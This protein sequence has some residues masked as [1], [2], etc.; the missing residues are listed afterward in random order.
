LILGPNHIQLSGDSGRQIEYLM[1]GAPD[2]AKHRYLQAWTLRHDSAFILMFSA[3]MA[4]FNQFKPQIDASLAS[5]L[6]R[7][8][9]AALLLKHTV[10]REITSMYGIPFVDKQ[11]GFR[12]HYPSGWKF[13]TS[14][15]TS[16]A[17]HCEYRGRLSHA[18]DEKEVLLAYDVT[19]EPCN[20][21]LAAYSARL[22]REL[23]KALGRAVTISIAAAPADEAAFAAL[24]VDCDA[25]GQHSL[26]FFPCRVG[27]R[28]GFMTR[29]RTVAL[30]ANASS[31]DA[32]AAASSAASTGAA[33]A[34]S[35]AASAYFELRWTVADDNAY[36]LTFVSTA[37]LDD[38]R[39]EP[40]FA[41]LASSFE[42]VPQ[43]YKSKYATRRYENLQ[44]GVRLDYPTNLAVH[45]KVMGAIVSFVEELPGE[46]FG[47]HVNFV[48]HRLED[49][50][51]SG[52]LEQF[53]ET[54]KQQMP[55]F[56]QDYAIEDEVAI[57]LGGQP[58][59]RIIY[60][61]RLQPFEAKFAQ[62]FTIKDGRAFILSYAVSAPRFED[63]FTRVRET[64][65]DS[66]CFF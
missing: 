37:T 2:G 25:P 51:L 14:R 1:I 19:A 7:P 31:V 50:N 56:V 16:R 64:V 52:D 44:L 22:R 40:L 3:P 38:R 49:M 28:D 62:F 36:V 9:A 55:S 32:A 20:D 21:T 27:E 13:H 59:K 41:R 45:E 47:S 6:I 53:A 46:E 35:A 63:E 58:G 34:S 24:A 10:Q 18:P 11:H 8:E 33:G 12:I 29:F 57:T 23:A 65:I 5:F 17:V 61:G 54:I 60:R 48:S 39:A 15:K 42:L 43:G 30:N 66:F 4:Q 26:Q